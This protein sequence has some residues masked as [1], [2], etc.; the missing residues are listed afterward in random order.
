MLDKFVLLTKPCTRVPL[1]GI[2]ILHI[3]F[4]LCL[5]LHVTRNLTTEIAHAIKTG[6]KYML[7]LF[8][9]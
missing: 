3:D 8:G 4:L 6:E 5:R 7:A 9:D 1:Y 2:V